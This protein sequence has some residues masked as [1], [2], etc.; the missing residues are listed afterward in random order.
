MEGIPIFTSV[1]QEIF[2]FMFDKVGHICKAGAFFNTNDI[3]MFRQ[4]KHGIRSHFNNHTTRNVVDDNWQIRSIRNSFEVLVHTFLRWL[5]VVRHDSKTSCETTKFGN[6]LSKLDRVACIVS[7][8]TC[9]QWHTSINNFLHS[10]KEFQ[11]LIVSKCWTFSCCSRQKKGFSMVS[12]K[13]LSQFW[14]GIIID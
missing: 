7:T 9:N 12:Q 13:M 3:W 11:L 8:D 4:T 6:F 1:N 14:K 10:R 2:R 5:V